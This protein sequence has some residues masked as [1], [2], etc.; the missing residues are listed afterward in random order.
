MSLQTACASIPHFLPGAPYGVWES[1]LW[2]SF[3]EQ[4]RLSNIQQPNIERL[5]EEVYYGGATLTNNGTAIISDACRV[6]LHN[7]E[8]PPG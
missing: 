7:I 5:V 2:K 1:C 3:L 8:K 4:G 6:M